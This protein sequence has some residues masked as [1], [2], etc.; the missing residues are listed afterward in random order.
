MECPECGAV[1]SDADLFCGECGAVL[2]EPLS[3]E[4]VE[5]S[6]PEPGGELAPPPAPDPTPTFAPAARDSRANAAYILGIVSIGLAAISCIPLVSF[7]SCVGPVTGIIAII[8]G[9]IVKR[10]VV[11]QGGLE[12]DRKKAHQGMMLG[13]VGTVLY[14]VMAVVGL[15]LSA[16]IGILSEM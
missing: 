11:A 6:A 10:D 13:I 15:V 2:A 16:S 5:A 8:L 3:E 14:F 12:E 4:F 9:A 1:I 7:V